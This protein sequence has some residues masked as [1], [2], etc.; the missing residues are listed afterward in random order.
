MIRGRG[1]RPYRPPQLLTGHIDDFPLVPETP[2][3]LPSRFEDRAPEATQTGLPVSTQDR[4]P[5]ATRTGLPVSTQDRAPEATVSGAR[6]ICRAWEIKRAREICRAGEIERAREISRD[7]QTIGN[8]GTDSRCAHRTD[9][10]RTRPTVV[11]I[12]PESGSRETIGNRGTPH[13]RSAHGADRRRTCPTVV[14]IRPESG[15]RE[16][17]G[18]RGASARRLHPPASRQQSRCRI[19][20]SSQRNG[21]NLSIRRECYA[22][23]PRKRGAPS[24]RSHNHDRSRGPQIEVQAAK[25]IASQKEENFHRPSACLASNSISRTA[26]SAATRIRTK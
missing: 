25:E 5:E 13:S 22:P 12:R 9:H 6:E 19:S 8:R 4:A 3:T 23:N 26:K 21:N 18:N 2:I 11:T 16:T 7:P 1:H 15:S 20:R 14:T 24:C 17:I 10:R